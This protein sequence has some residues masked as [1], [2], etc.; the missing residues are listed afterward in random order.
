MI[1]CSDGGGGTSLLEIEAISRARWMYVKSRPV[2][3]TLRKTNARHCL[4]Q[5]STAAGLL[6]V[7]GAAEPVERM[8]GR[9]CGKTLLN[10]EPL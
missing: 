3:Q 9:C 5:P 2:G 4:L 8:C 7:D 6:C 10:L 1:L